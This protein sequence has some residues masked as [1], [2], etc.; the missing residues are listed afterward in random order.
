MDPD[1]YLLAKQLFLAA[2]QTP[3]SGRTAWVASACRGD[4]ALEREVL[5][6]LAAA[7][8]RDD[9]LEGPA[10]DALRTDSLP[11]GPS[12]IAGYRVLGL[13]GHGGMGVVYRARRANDPE[14][15]LKLLDAGPMADRT[16]SRFRRE[17]EALRRLQHP[18]IA[19]ILEAGEFASLL[20]PQPWIAM[21]LVDGVS[22]RTRAQDGAW[23]DRER[24]RFVVEVARA[25]A[26]AHAQGVV[27]RD[28]KPDNLMIG[29]DG[30][31]VILDFGI[32]RIARGD[33]LRGTLTVTGEVLG[34]IHYMSP[35]QA[36]GQLDEID[37][38]SD[39]YS[40]A[41]VAYELLAGALPYTLATRSLTRALVQVVTTPPRPIGAVRRNLR[42]GLE[43]I[44][45]KALEKHPADRQPNVGA[46]AD[47]LQRWLEGR[48]VAALRGRSVRRLRAWV[49]T[50]GGLLTAAVMAVAVV[51]TAVALST[52]VVRHRIPPLATA[53]R[54]AILARL[55]EADLLLHTV[56][57]SRAGLARALGIYLGARRSLTTFPGDTLSRDLIRYV[58][59]RL[60]ET[61]FMMGA[62]DHDPDALMRSDESFHAMLNV[63]RPRT[64]VPPLDHYDP[65]FGRL[66]GM[67]PEEGHSGAALA[68]M[69]LARYMD[70]AFNVRRALEDR[71]SAI[72]IFVEST[73]EHDL[74]HIANGSIAVQAAKLLN[75]LGESMTAFAALT[76]SVPLFD[77]GL[78][79]LRSAR[80]IELLRQQD[81]VAYASVLQ[82][83]GQAFLERAQRGDAA[84]VDSSRAC[85]DEALAIR[86]DWKRLSRTDTRLSLAEL[87]LAA[88]AFAPRQASARFATALSLVDQARQDLVADTVSRSAW[89]P[90]WLMRA[91]VLLE[92]RTHGGSPALVI[93]AR[94]ALDSAAGPID[95]RAEP[96]TG[97]AIA[98]L[99]ARAARLADPPSPDEAARQLGRARELTTADQDRALARQLA[100]EQRALAAHAFTR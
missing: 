98:W 87:E 65:V 23:S 33:D 67:T 84:A 69:E 54:G 63:A 3:E 11:D 18:G 62:A 9:V 58:S 16:T 99:R 44:L 25:L 68:R 90:T 29:A 56:R 43:A 66:Q 28:L 30:H 46:F 21:E 50:R 20:G 75:E 49:R 5:D 74:A 45:E 39:L 88:V 55:Q 6:L 26:H 52:D 61:Y 82:N 41:V 15:A 37:G 32:A 78:A 95:A 91:R 83:L 85:L 70:P 77:P 89:V 59:M 96:R 31:A 7:A 79:S 17:V 86:V 60:G 76:D 12:E 57:P 34:T 92:Q 48:S 100:A 94:A 13:L 1:R 42:G 10:L 19:R 71:R 27:H 47:D 14:V 81:R 8:T 24:V 22:L 38:R 36:Q 93:A 97:A 72:R 53:D 73:G 51:L 40:L 64:Y 35:E 80:A 2:L 4:V